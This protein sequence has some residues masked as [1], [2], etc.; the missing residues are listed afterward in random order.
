MSNSIFYW[1][2]GFFATFNGK[3]RDFWKRSIWEQKTTQLT[4]CFFSGFFPQW[5]LVQFETFLNIK[6]SSSIA[7]AFY[8]AFGCNGQMMISAP[9]SSAKIVE[10]CHN[11]ETI[12]QKPWKFFR[13]MTQMVAPTIQWIILLFVDLGDLIRMMDHFGRSFEPCNQSTVHFMYT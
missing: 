13:L 6:I 8:C 3:S 11:F 1:I 9:F 12:F 10:F 7:K 4:N 5:L 2:F